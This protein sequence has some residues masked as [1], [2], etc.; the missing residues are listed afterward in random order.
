MDQDFDMMIDLDCF[1]ALVSEEKGQVEGMIC[2]IIGPKF[3]SYGNVAQELVWYV[4]KESRTC[5]IRL[6]RAFEKK[7]LDK[8]LDYIFMVGLSDSKAVNIY[9]RLGYKQMEITFKKRLGG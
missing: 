7:C 8:G 2:A 3:F 5:G 4:R 6:L 1:M 9:K